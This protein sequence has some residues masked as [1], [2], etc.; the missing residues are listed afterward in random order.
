MF[1]KLGYMLCGALLAAA[2]GTAFAVTGTPPG[3]GPSLIDG[4]WLNALAGGLNN[5]FQSGITAAGTTQATATALTSG[6]KLVE[7][8]T[9]AGNTGVNLPSALA[10]ASINIYN[11]G[12]NIVTVYPAVANNPIT[13]IQDTINAG[14]STPLTPTFALV[15]STARN[16]IWG[17]K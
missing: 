15:C 7:I 2:V 5:T 8:D 12:A 1:K 3:T 9:A 13:A 14:V 6:V 11:A 4:A 16:G 10:G 17:C